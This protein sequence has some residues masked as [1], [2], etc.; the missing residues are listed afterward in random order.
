ML[1]THRHTHMY[2][3]YLIYFEIKKLSEKHVNNNFN[4]DF[5]NHYS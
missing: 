2:L 3:L 5:N 4:N 1:Y